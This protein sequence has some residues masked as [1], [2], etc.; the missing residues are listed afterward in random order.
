MNKCILVYR[1]RAFIFL[2]LLIFLSSALLLVSC[3]NDVSEDTD[4]LSGD[5]Y[6]SIALSIRVVENTVPSIN[7]LTGDF[8]GAATVDGASR[9][10]V[11][12]LDSGGTF[13]AGGGP[14]NWSQGSGTVDG[15]PPGANRKVIVRVYDPSGTT[16][17][18]Q[19]GTKSNISITKGSVTDLSGDPI[20]VYSPNT[21]VINTSPASF[22]DD[23]TLNAPVDTIISV[24]F[25]AAIDSS[26]VYYGTSFK[27]YE[28]DDSGNIESMV[29]GDIFF[30]D[31]NTILYF[32]P[33]NTLDF[34]TVY[35]ISVYPTIKDLSGNTIT[36]YVGAFGTGD[37]GS[38]DI[39]CTD[40]S[41]T[42]PV[43]EVQTFDVSSGGETLT[44]NYIIFE[45]TQSGCHVEVSDGTTTFQGYVNG[46]T[47]NMD[48]VEFQASDEVKA[49]YSNWNFW[50]DGSYLTGSA[51][52][53]LEDIWTGSEYSGTSIF[54]TE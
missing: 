50:L 52:W 27:I 4:L 44:P 30:N 12:V 37:S 8:I 24:T 32:T 20:I 53:M 25:S 46:T 18:Y 29:V 51:T 15:V 21:R 39:S 1:L 54:Y 41:G 5:E 33:G 45:I 38:T 14:W 17:L 2:Y 26:T 40:F 13:L 10:K 19:G 22:I 6:G 34:N 49:S 28:G 16:L 9:V 3:G 7:A 31:D 43:Y 36:A 48:Y 47:L 11:D 42:Y 23:Y 35:G